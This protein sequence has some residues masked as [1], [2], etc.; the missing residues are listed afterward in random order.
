MVINTNGM[1]MAMSL[2]EEEIFLKKR[3]DQLMNKTQFQSN[4]IITSRVAVGL[5]PSRCL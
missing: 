5:Y 2:G 1:Q 4:N 3:K